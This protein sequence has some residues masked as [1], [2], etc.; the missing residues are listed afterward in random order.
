LATVRAYDPFGRDEVS[1]RKA[2]A[3]FPNAGHRRFPKK[4]NAQGPCLI[5]HFFV[6]YRAA[7]SHSQS[8]WKTGCC[9]LFFFQKFYSLERIPLTGRNFH[10]ELLES[11]N[12]IGHQAL[13]AGF[14]NRGFVSICDHH[15]ETSTSRRDCRG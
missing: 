4:L 15:M 10:A 1:S 3:I 9:R 14:I 5:Q 2:Y 7:Q 11:G 12:R 13:A 6:E 8:S